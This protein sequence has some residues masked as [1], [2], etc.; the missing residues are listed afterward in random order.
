M[1]DIKELRIGN[2]VLYKDKKVRIT[3][4]SIGL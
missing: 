2:Y 1:I 3:G 4:N